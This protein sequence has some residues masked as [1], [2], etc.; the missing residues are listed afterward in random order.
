MFP[1]AA[2]G[3]DAREEGGGAAGGELLSMDSLLLPGMSAA[4]E[5]EL[6]HDDD[7]L[8]EEYGEEEEARPGAHGANVHG[9]RA[10]AAPPSDSDHPSVALPVFLEEPTD[11]YVVKSKPATLQCRAAHALQVRLFTLCIRNI[12]KVFVEIYRGKLSLISII[13]LFEWSVYF[14]NRPLFIIKITHK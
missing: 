14:I 8:E 9:P 11:A 3:P 4:H 1:G 7:E 5:E 13:Y 6:D 10:S 12:S 2:G